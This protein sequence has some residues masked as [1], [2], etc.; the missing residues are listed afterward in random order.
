MDSEAFQLFHISG[1]GVLLIIAVLS[2]FIYYSRSK[3]L[4]KDFNMEV[5]VCC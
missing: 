3:T 4:L 1:S 5:L 2:G